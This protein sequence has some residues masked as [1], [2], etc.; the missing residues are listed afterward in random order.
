MSRKLTFIYL[1]YAITFKGG[2]QKCVY[3]AIKGKLYDV[4]L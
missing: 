2:S 1:F 4:V 3:M